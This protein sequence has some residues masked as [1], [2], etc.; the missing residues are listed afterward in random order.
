MGFGHVAKP[1]SRGT[2]SIAKEGISFG[3]LTLPNGGELMATASNGVTAKY[4]N[5]AIGNT[6]KR[7][8]AAPNPCGA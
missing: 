6:D 2:V 3:Y 7:I 8:A 5:Y 4:A 1:R